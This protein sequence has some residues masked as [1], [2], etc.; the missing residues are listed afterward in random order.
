MSQATKEATSTESAE[1]GIVFVQ[2]NDPE[3]CI[4]KKA[5]IL[6]LKD[7]DSSILRTVSHPGMAL[8]FQ[9]T[10]KTESPDKIMINLALVPTM[11]APQ[12]KYDGTFISTTIQK[13]GDY[14]LDAYKWE[15]KERNKINVFRHA[16]DESRTRA[17]DDDEGVNGQAFVFNNEQVS[18]S[19]TQN[20]PILKGSIS[21]RDNAHI[22]L[23]RRG[24]SNLDDLLI[25]S[26]LL[27]NQTEVRLLL[28]E[29]KVHVNTIF[30]GNSALRRAV[31]KGD[32]QM[33][34]F[35]LQRGASPNP[36]V[37][38]GPLNEACFHGHIEIV[39]SLIENGANVNKENFLGIT[40]I[41]V[42]ALSG[43]HD[44]VVA[45][46]QAGAN[47][48]GGK[49]PA[50]SH[51]ILNGHPQCLKALLR[52]GASIDIE[53]K[54]D[55]N[56]RPLNQACTYGMT[57]G[58][59]FVTILLHE[60]GDL[61]TDQIVSKM[62]QDVLLHSYA[63]KLNEEML[64]KCIALSYAKFGAE[65]AFLSCLQL[66]RLAHKRDLQLRATNISFADSHGRLAVHL[67]LG[68]AAI[69][70]V[71]YKDDISYRV[72][73][74]AYV[75]TSK[76]DVLAQ[77]MNHKRCQHALSIAQGMR[78]TIFF[79]KS[80]TLGYMNRKWYGNLLFS[81]ITET[82]TSQWEACCKM[83]GIILLIFLQIPLLLVTMLPTNSS[84]RKRNFFL[85]SYPFIRFFFQCCTD[86]ILAICF[87]N[88]EVKDVSLANLHIQLPLFFVLG[89]LFALELRIVLTKG[90]KAYFMDRFKYFDIPG[91]LFSILAITRGFFPSSDD[92]NLLRVSMCLAS[93]FLW[94]RVLRFLMLI[95]SVGP[96]VLMMFRMISDV[97]QWLSLFIIVLLA[98]SSGVQKLTTT[99]MDYQFSLRQFFE[100]AL[101]A[102]GTEFEA[103]Y[104]DENK[105]TKHAGLITVYVS[106]LIGNVL[107]LN[108]LIAIMTESFSS[109]WEAQTE[110]YQ[111]QRASHC[112]DMDHQKD[113]PFSI[114]YLP[115]SLYELC[116]VLLLKK[117]DEYEDVTES[118]V[119][120]T[121][122]NTIV[123]DIYEYITEF[124]D[125]GGEE[126]RWRSKL[127]KRI[128]K[129]EKDLC[130]RMD[131]I[132][133]N[134]ISKMQESLDEKLKELATKDK[135]I[136]I[137]TTKNEELITL[138]RDLLKVR[139]DKL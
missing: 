82:K 69:L 65:K 5:A 133:M 51:S 79:S 95:P 32:M 53:W 127:S 136:E 129:V 52:H 19:H 25:E 29:K 134:N 113:L 3:K 88:L 55:N 109:V 66:A 124:Q 70:K 121:T 38:L 131:K 26:A 138:V 42:A 87:T 120:A 12:W 92:D 90:H 98:F 97:I 54:H 27:G 56:G 123:K 99:K 36:D 85:L 101:Q 20:T 135:N 4:F 8:G 49:I 31:M 22:F 48:D 122:D 50:L 28:D 119:P 100:D 106:F 47:I 11:N 110:N 17:S 64:S 111:Y 40:P 21:P 76:D 44:C 63:T 61:Q 77:F 57:R 18:I 116:C 73:N 68:A 37:Q 71:I 43:K 60:R 10:S 13:D 93:I 117:V 15:L 33:V 132:A 6:T 45:M 1:D 58:L 7:G 9:R 128:G 81:M 89:G 112:I 30:E 14:I 46:I 2:R 62:G 107:L 84:I 23:G 137:L 34:N 126:E 41:S 24:N 39:Q 115:F 103:I 80:E 83:L 125:D 130:V 35:L 108:M 75:K 72:H 59:E 104:V 96:L 78:A 118:Y 105:V 86:A 91:L 74:S 102:D 139:E 16:T 114:F 67:Q 94:L